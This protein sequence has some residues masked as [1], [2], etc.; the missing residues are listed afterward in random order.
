MEE[1]NMVSIEDMF[2]DIEAEE[3]LEN[4]PTEYSLEDLFSMADEIMS[5]DI[6]QD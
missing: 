1:F 2:A 4:D 3:L 6:Y 5:K